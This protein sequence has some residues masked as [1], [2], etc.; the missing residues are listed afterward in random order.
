MSETKK[1]IFDSQEEKDFDAYLRELKDAG[2]IEHYVYHPET[3]ML[4]DKFS[5]K[6]KDIK[7][8]IKEEHLLHDIKYTYDFAIL[9]YEK[10]KH[11]FYK[12]INDLNT[13]YDK[14]KLPFYAFYEPLDDTNWSYIDVKGDFAG[15][16]NNSAITFPLLQKMML[17]IKDK[18]VQKIIP[19]KLFE[20]TFVPKEL[21]YTE[22]TKKE[23]K[24]PF[25]KRTLEEFLNL[26][27][28]KDH[29]LYPLTKE[30]CFEKI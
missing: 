26:S 10:G 18:Y 28:Y 4:F 6:F 27:G 8:I 21:W 15:P 13:V 7:G 24:F 12:S 11:L 3:V 25:E 17:H 20:K 16:H 9:W 23:R 30:E 1:I 5:V 2:F 29:R 14:K 22:K 19:K